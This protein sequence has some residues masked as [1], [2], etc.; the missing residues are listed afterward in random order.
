MTVWK[1]SRGGAQ[2]GNHVAKDAG[3]SKEE[4]EASRDEACQ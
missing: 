4:D 2:D 1:A 3:E